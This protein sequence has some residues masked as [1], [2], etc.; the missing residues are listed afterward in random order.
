MKEIYIEKFF[1][2]LPPNL[3]INETKRS[4]GKRTKNETRTSKKDLLG[5]KA[6]KQTINLFIYTW[7]HYSV[8]EERQK[9][10]SELKLLPHN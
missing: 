6:A 8:Q 3:L 9:L 4:L 10:N 5:L 1:K 7:I 2:S